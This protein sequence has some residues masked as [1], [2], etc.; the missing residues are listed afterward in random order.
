[1]TD[2]HSPQAEVLAFLLDPATHGCA[3]ENIAHMETHLSEI[4]LAGDLVFKLKRAVRLPYADFSTYALRLSACRRELELNRRTAPNL[5][6]AVRKITRDSGGHLQFDGQGEEIDAV[7][8]M[9]R[10]DQQAIL[11]NV[12]KHNAL[13]N[14]HLEALAREIARF[15]ES[16]VIVRGDGSMLDL[17]DLNLAA[18][19]TSNFFPQDTVARFDEECRHLHARHL[20]LLSH[21]AQS[22][23]RRQCH[24]DM[25]LRNICLINDIPVLFDC[26]EFN[27][28]LST[29]D[30]L[31]DLAFLLMDLWR[32][33]LRAQANLVLNRYLDTRD[34]EDGLPLLPFF[35][36]LRAGIRAHVLA[37]HAAD[38]TAPDHEQV[39]NDAHRY[40]AL[41][42]EL[43]QPAQARVVAISGKSG[44]GKSTVAAACAHRIGPPPGA[45]ILSSDR[46]RKKLLGVEACTRLP[47]DAYSS[48]MSEKVY[49]YQAAHVISLTRA[50]T[51]VIA[52]AVFNRPEDRRRLEQAA[53][54]AHVRFSAVCLVAPVDTLIQRVTT[55]TSGPSDADAALVIAQNQLDDHRNQW[56]EIDTSGTLAETVERV[57]R[58]LEENV[59]DGAAS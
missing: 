29:I 40:M 33:E 59:P 37:T 27:P 44:T 42:L 34:D 31:Y 43:L 28:A 32:L 50:G 41:A 2:P 20:D 25:H 48:T 16:A 9:S 51:G 30:V 36:A 46:I 7:V 22:G 24:G 5:Y 1:M 10:F 35:M 58:A 18:F 55:R 45:R 11:E 15:H 6:R 52:D 14:R 26:L 53:A 57:T 12:A 19:R 54:A 38:R 56:P 39:C 3:R 4:I 21:R 49:A 13:S 23:S 17:L 47:P 8:E